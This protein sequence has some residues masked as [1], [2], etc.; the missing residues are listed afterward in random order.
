MFKYPE[1]LTYS[2]LPKTTCYT[3]VPGFVYNL[4][5]PRHSSARL[6][7]DGGGS[8][9]PYSYS[10]RYKQPVFFLFFFSFFNHTVIYMH[11]AGPPSLLIILA[12]ACMRLITMTTVPNTI[13]AAAT[14]VFHERVVSLM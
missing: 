14:Y 2:S 5:T 1:Y 8:L 7:R 11:F 3:T 12:T 9:V 4:F 10:R 6:E 13:I